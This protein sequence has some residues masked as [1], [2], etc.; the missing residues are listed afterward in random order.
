MVSKYDNIYTRKHLISATN[1]H[2]RNVGKLRYGNRRPLRQNAD[3][4]WQHRRWNT[5]VSATLAADHDDAD[6][7]QRWAN[8]AMLGGRLP[9]Q[10]SLGLRQSLGLRSTGSPCLS[11]GTTQGC[12]KWRTGQTS[13]PQAD[14]DRAEKSGQF[15]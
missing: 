5:N 13:P 10:V 14:F 3:I 11:S 12:T 7:C 1:V 8:V 15:Y 4:L 6:Q 2:T 9:G